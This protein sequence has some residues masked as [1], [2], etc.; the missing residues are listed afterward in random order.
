MCS[1]VCP[2]MAYKRSISEVLFVNVIRVA[3]GDGDKSTSLGAGT[4]GREGLGLR[5]FVSGV[6]PCI[7]QISSGHNH[8]VLT[9]NV[10]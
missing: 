3:S 9:A 7:S 2:V 4:A 1:A 8:E 10:R 6:I 5:P